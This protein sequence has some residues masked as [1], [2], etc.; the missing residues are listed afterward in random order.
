MIEVYDLVPIGT[1][2]HIIGG[3]Y[4]GRI[5]KEGVEPGSDIAEVQRRL[6][7]LGY[8][9]GPVDGVYNAQTRAA[10]TAFQSKQGLTPDGTVG[11]MTYSALQR[12]YDIA[13]GNREP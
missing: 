10:V 4:T 12:A 13:T 5:L 11:P 3:A 2:V 8:Y 1:P 9:R 7:V 6:Q